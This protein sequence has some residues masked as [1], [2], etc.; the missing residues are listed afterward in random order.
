MAQLHSAKIG[1]FYNG[2]RDVGNEQHNGGFEKKL[3][4]FWK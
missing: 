2:F 4:T 3:D 1:K